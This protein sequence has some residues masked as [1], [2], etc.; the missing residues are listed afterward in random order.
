[1]DETPAATADSPEAAR[2]RQQAE[3]TLRRLV[4]SP[5]AALR[6]DQWAAIRALVV[7]GRRALV[8]Q[9]TGWGKS[10][11]YFVATALLRASGAGPT[12]IV[13]PLLALMR[14]QIGAAARAGITART[15][16]SAN[17][18]EWAAIQ[19][20]VAAGAVDVLLVSPERL[21]HSGASPTPAAV[22]AR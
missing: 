14:N 18:E 22:G 15:I 5:D 10:A 6:D 1:M 4:G 19:Q 13:S 2:V 11:V 21:R 12:V 9:R 3:E 16:N 17:P 8:V 7:E 20:E